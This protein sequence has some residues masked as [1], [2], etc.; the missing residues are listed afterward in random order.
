MLNKYTIWI[1]MFVSVA[2]INVGLK[3]NKKKM[4][5]FHSHT[6]QNQLRRNKIYRIL[7]N[8]WPQNLYTHYMN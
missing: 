2:K 4:K 6:Q 1:C 7:N 8:I 3:I 5:K